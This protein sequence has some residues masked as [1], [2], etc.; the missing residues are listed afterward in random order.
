MLANSGVI[1]PEWTE[2]E[3]EAIATDT[4]EARSKRFKEQLLERVEVRRACE[5][6]EDEPI[7]RYTWPQ[8][9]TVTIWNSGAEALHR[10]SYPV[11][12][13]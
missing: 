2:V 9:R 8:R 12:R 4:E 1:P 11:A 6:Y 10:Q 13:V 5:Q 7:V 3:E